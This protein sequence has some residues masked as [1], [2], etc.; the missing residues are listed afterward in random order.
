MIYWY[1]TYIYIFT[2]KI[3]FNLVVRKLISIYLR[4]EMS[5]VER[6]IQLTN[7]YTTGGETFEKGSIGTVIGETTRKG[8]KYLKIKFDKDTK[9]YRLI[10]ETDLQ[11]Y[12]FKNEKEVVCL[13]EPKLQ[14][15]CQSTDLQAY[16]FKNEKEVVCRNEP[17]LQKNCQSNSPTSD[18]ESIEY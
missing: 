4:D 5:G 15:N 14:K 3:Y 1:I 2:L 11:A 17:K 18:D 9:N 7:D 8:R 10:K 6:R 13:N 12:T 16:T